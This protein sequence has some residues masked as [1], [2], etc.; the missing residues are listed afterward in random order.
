VAQA[1]ASAVEVYGKGDLA[2]YLVMMTA[3]LLA[4]PAVL[5]PSASLYL[6]CDP[7][8]SHLLRLVLDAIWGPAAFRR[9]IVWRSGWVSGFK[10]T[11]RT[12]VRNHDVLLYLTTGPDFTFHKAYTAHPEGYRR[13]GGGPG[14]ARGRPVEDVWT[15]IY[16]PWIQ[17]FS[18]EKTGFATQKPVA[19]LQRIIAASSNPGD[20][21]LDPFAGSGTTLVAARRLGRYAVGIEQ[22]PMA[23]AITRARL[24]AEEGAVPPAPEVWPVAGLPSRASPRATWRWAGLAFVRLGAHPVPRA[25]RSVPD[26][27]LRAPAGEVLARVRVVPP[28]GNPPSREDLGHLL[29]P[30][31]ADPIPPW[32][33]LFP[34]ALPP[35]RPGHGMPWPQDQRAAEAPVHLLDGEDLEHLD[36]TA[37]WWP[38]RRLHPLAA[39]VARAPRR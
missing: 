15:D 25:D 33:V 23:R 34:W 21:V 27:E 16:S 12:W 6:H 19:L 38:Q 29:E 39:R 26:G 11:V 24:L 28:E 10:G 9:E 7:T 8:A 1:L 36:E 17:S 13:R 22:E 20:R 32:L 2:S 30:L 4:L 31:A 3:R 5:A 35:H 18:R 14:S 37:E